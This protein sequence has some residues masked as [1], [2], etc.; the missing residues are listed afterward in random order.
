MKVVLDTNVVASGLFFSGPPS[1]ILEGVFSGT[2]TPVMTAEI[3]EEYVHILVE[4]GR[5]Y[6]GVDATPLLDEIIRQ[7]EVIS[8]VGLLRPAC[9]D[10]DDDKFFAC[11]VA[12]NAKLIISGD[13]HLLDA[14]GTFGV[15]V[16]TPRAFVDGYLSGR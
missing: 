2:V 3:I 13:R 16:L 9:A 5:R 7:G 15:E 14:S 11:A 8:P 10:P 6:P 1:V 12:R 4:L